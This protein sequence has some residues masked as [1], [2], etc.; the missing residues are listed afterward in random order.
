VNTKT[1]CSVPLG[2]RAAD[3][4]GTFEIFVKKCFGVAR[5]AQVYALGL[6][7]YTTHAKVLIHDASTDNSPLA[8]ALFEPVINCRA[9]NV[10][11]CSDTRKT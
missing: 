3:L 9:L 4:E 7:I 1:P 10:K 8:T 6:Y 11:T 2:A 5:K